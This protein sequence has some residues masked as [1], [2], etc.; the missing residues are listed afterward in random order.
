MHAAT[1]RP[2]QELTL[3]PN[4]ILNRGFEVVVQDAG[5]LLEATDDG[6]DA[7]P[8]LVPDGSGGGPVPDFHAVAGARV[9]PE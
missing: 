2:Q 3:V 8:M 6:E 1:Q 7:L 4:A 9:L 5:E